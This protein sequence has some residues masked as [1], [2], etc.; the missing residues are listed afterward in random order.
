MKIQAGTK[1][2]V[3]VLSMLVSCPILGA[4]TEDPLVTARKLANAGKTAESEAALHQFIASN[5]SSADAYFLLGY[6]YFR[7]AKPRESL[8]A[9]TS[10]ARFRH[11]EANELKIVASDYVLLRDFPDAQK[12][13]SEVTR[14]TPNDSDAWYLLGRTQYNEDQF[15]NAIASFE[16]ALKLRPHYI[17]AEN[18]LGLAWEGLNKLDEASAAYRQAIAWQGSQPSDPQPYLNLGTLLTNQNHPEKA[19]PFLQRASQL[20]PENPKIHE[21]LAFALEACNRL[22]EAQHQLEKA[23]ALAPKASGP[24]FKLGRLYQREGLADLARQQFAICQKLYGT[25]DSTDTPNPYQR[26]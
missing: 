13:F 24:H 5:P 9:F 17:E 4:Q 16:Q 10:G 1:L 7:E 3:F 12:W 11:P 14:L 2:A 19:I 6:V 26:K 8:A 25:H 21:E 20:A 23:V 22:P 18:N 15:T